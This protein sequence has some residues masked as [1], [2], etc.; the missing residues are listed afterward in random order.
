MGSVSGASQEDTPQESISQ[1]LVNT[2][3]AQATVEYT[4]TPTSGICEEEDF[5]VTVT[6]NPSIIPSR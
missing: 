3:Q 5:L 2:T 6:V 1:D 4:V